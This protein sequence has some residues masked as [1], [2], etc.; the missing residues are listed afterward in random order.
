MEAKEEE[1][2]V[3]G[4]GCPGHTA[5][6]TVP[7]NCG[8]EEDCRLKVFG[9]AAGDG[10]IIRDKSTLRGFCV[11]VLES[12]GKENLPVPEGEEDADGMY[13]SEKAAELAETR[14]GILLSLTESDAPQLL[15]RW[16]PEFG[17][18]IYRAEKADTDW[19]GVFRNLSFRDRA[20]AERSAV[21][22]TALYV[23]VCYADLYA[24][25]GD[26]GKS[27]MKIKY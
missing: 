26:G 13:P 15:K 3:F 7:E 5:A 2:R 19:S 17:Y 1:L 4:N 16:T 22:L 14:A 23:R 8:E 20:Q 18:M 25:I 27:V 9:Q 24:K 6:V 11:S 21:R 12:I 10:I